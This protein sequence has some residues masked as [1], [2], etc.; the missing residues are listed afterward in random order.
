MT[1]EGSGDVS[2]KTRCPSMTTDEVAKRSRRVPV[3]D[4]RRDRTRSTKTDLLILCDRDILVG[5]V[6]RQCVPKRRPGS[7]VRDGRRRSSASCWR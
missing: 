2:E 7:R 3:H 1:P 4:V 6:P 5:M